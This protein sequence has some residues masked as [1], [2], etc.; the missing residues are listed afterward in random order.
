MIGYSSWILY[1][2][3]L[4]SKSTLGREICLKWDDY[5]M[6]LD[7]VLVSQFFCLRNISFFFVLGEVPI[8]S[9]VFLLVLYLMNDEG[10]ILL[11]ACLCM[12]N[13][14]ILNF[15]RVLLLRHAHTV[16]GT[17]TVKLVYVETRYLTL[18]S[19]FAFKFNFCL[20]ERSFCSNNH[21]SHLNCF[22]TCS[23][24]CILASQE[25]RLREQAT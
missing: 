4:S 6:F 25:M 2:N 9:S 3:F 5:I 24:M 17:A 12:L 11:R 8:S 13:A 14:G 21:L 19:A 1:I 23:M 10:K 15:R 18:V 22:Y 16:V 20:S 7:I